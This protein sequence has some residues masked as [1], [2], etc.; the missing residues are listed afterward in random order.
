VLSPVGLWVEKVG[1][2]MF[3]GGKSGAQFF[4]RKD[5]PNPLNPSLQGQGK[6]PNHPFPGER[7]TEDV[8]VLRP[9]VKCTIV[10]IS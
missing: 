2:M 7:L 6:P 4:P 8:L 5:K 3:K 9:L 10:T 1:K